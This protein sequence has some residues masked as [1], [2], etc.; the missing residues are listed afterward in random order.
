MCCVCVCHCVCCVC[1]S[2]C[3]LC[4]CVTVCVHGCACVLFI[5]SSI[6]LF[7]PQISMNVPLMVQHSVN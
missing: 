7:F 2:L 5:F 4:V 3:V 1:V 6:V